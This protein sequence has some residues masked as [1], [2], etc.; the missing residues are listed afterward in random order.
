MVAGGPG[1]I[2][3]PGRD[4]GV[5]VGGVAERFPA[6]GEIKGDAEEC[7]A[8]LFGGGFFN[9]ER[10]TEATGYAVALD[11]ER[12]P[13]VGLEGA[14]GADAI[15]AKVADFTGGSG[16]IGLAVAERDEEHDLAIGRDI[17]GSDTAATFD[18]LFL[19][20][21]ER[22]GVAH[23]DAQFTVGIGGGC[24][25]RQIG[26]WQGFGH[27]DGVGRAAVGKA[28]GGLREAGAEGECDKAKGEARAGGHG[29]VGKAANFEG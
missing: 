5:G 24:R 16:K 9:A 20:I 17:D 7:F 8:G 4:A 12:F 18:A 19:D 6:Y 15:A 26:D 23:D 29:E 27:A 1:F 22:Y 2:G 28:G 21:G 10:Q 13:G 11:F 14:F 25:S 3:A